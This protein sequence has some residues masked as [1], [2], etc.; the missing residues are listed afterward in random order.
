M[1]FAGF[2]PE[3]IRSLQ[4]K[5]AAISSAAPVV[6]SG[7]Q[8]IKSAFTRTAGTTPNTRSG[9]PKV[10]S[11]FGLDGQPPIIK[12]RVFEPVLP[13]IKAQ[14]QEKISRGEVKTAPGIAASTQ[15]IPGLPALPLWAWLGIGFAILKLLKIV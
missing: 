15:I 6:S 12:S 5:A 14:L 11:G 2:T 9:R 1:A 3:L 7:F 4:N 13:Q 8:R 10:I